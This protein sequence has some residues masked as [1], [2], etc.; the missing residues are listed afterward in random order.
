MP[1]SFSPQIQTV[2]CTYFKHTSQWYY[3][4]DSF[5]STNKQNTQLNRYITKTTKLHSTIPAGLKKDCN[6]QFK[7]LL[8]HCLV[9]F[10]TRVS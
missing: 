10:P 1:H 7:L 6:A 5:C 8:K 9:I 3:N 2:R 4:E